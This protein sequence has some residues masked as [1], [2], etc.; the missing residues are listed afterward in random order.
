MTTKPE[1]YTGARKPQ[2]ATGPD[3]SDDFSQEA[4]ENRKPPLGMGLAQKV[5]TGD[6]RAAK[7]DRKLEKQ[8]KPTRDTRETPSPDPDEKH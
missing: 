7:K 8:A 2:P 6:K 3:P 4:A 1:Y 5:S